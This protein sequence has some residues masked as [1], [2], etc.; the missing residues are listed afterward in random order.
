MFCVDLTGVFYYYPKKPDNI[1]WERQTHGKSFPGAVRGPHRS[2]RTH[3]PLSPS[4][5]SSPHL[6]QELLPEAVAGAAR[7][8]SSDRR[9][10][11]L[12]AEAP[13]VC[14]RAEDSAQLKPVRT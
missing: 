2:A 8:H 9:P 6:S 4:G 1:L 5:P 10:P 7:M 14:P 3:Q 11:L 12:P 13:P